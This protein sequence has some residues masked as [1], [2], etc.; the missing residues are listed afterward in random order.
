MLQLAAST[1]N[2]QGKG[3]HASRH[4]ASAERQL[5]T[6][7]QEQTLVDW[8]KHQGSMGLPFLK[9]ELEAW[10]SK[11]AGR[12]V[13][14]SW[15]KNFMKRHRDDISA[16]KGVQLNPKCTSNFNKTVINGY[17]DRL[18]ALHGH[19]SGEIP[20][21]H[22]WNM[23]K[24]GIQLGGGCKNMGTMYFYSRSQKHK[25]RLKSD[26]LELVTVLKCVSAAGDIVPPSFCLQ[27]GSAPD[28]HSLHDDQWERYLRT[29]QYLFSGPE[30]TEAINVVL[31]FRILDGQTHTIASAGYE[32]FSF[33]SQNTVVLIIQSQ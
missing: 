13:G 26:N 25:S 29:L 3:H 23:D 11:L 22:I 2:D 14:V 33:H 15:Y 24:K 6:P 8:V 30:I 32:K 10:A 19:F 16:A 5:L 28:L 4:E 7:N 21:E 12:Q 27:S 9:K 20:A 1:L 31:I 17:F 18:E